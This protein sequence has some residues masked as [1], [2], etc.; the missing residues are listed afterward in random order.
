MLPAA[1][2]G[3]GVAVGQDLAYL[4]GSV[5]IVIEEK[6]LAGWKEAERP[7]AAHILLLVIASQYVTVAYGAAAA[8]H[9]RC[10]RTGRPSSSSHGPVANARLIVSEMKTNTRNKVCESIRR[11][12]PRF[13][14]CFFFLLC[15]TRIWFANE[16]FKSFEM[17]VQ[18][19]EK[20]H[21][22]VKGTVTTRDSQCSFPRLKIWC[23]AVIVSGGGGE[24]Y[25]KI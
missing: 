12:S 6:S 22:F 19:V 18:R 9:L 3:E 23:Q 4:L 13:F 2:A 5:M 20:K 15:E 8:A 24:C 25:V 10:D 14:V 17:G 21:L 16:E 11:S 7:S 1:A